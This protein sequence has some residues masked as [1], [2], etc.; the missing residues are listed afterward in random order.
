MTTWA[1]RIAA[2][3][4]LLLG[5][6]AL[7]SAQQPDAGKPRIIV[8][9]PPPPGPA[10][11]TPGRG[12]QKPAP[13]PGAAAPAPGGTAPAMAMPV[14]KPAPQMEQL[15]FFVGK[16]KCAGK[17]LASPLFGPEHPVEGS[18]EAKMEGENFW[19][20]FTYEEKKSKVHPGL[21]VRGM[22]GW[23]DTSKRFVRAAGDNRGSWDSGTSLGLVDNK[24]VWGGD[25]S[26]GPAGRV[27]YRQTFAK[28]SDREWTQT[29]ELQG[30]DGKWNALE[31]VTCKR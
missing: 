22:W 11:Y 24:L 16:W 23:D 20:S 26:G 7:S 17:Q 19:Q 6:A 12:G 9:P 1:F 15:K 27:P 18:A 4:A 14:T 10:S 25:L 2:P 21:K 31:E 8:P 3:A 29:L 28:K 30:R 5:A 13:P